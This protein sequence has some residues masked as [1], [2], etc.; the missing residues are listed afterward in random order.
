MHLPEQAFAS[1][2][3]CA[4]CWH[5]TGIEARC[6][7]PAMLAEL[8]YA[9]ETRSPGYGLSERSEN[10]S[11]RYAPVIW[12]SPALARYQPGRTLKL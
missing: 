11:F 3:S 5:A 12:H 1:N 4:N 10:V 7:S 2:W 8:V 6:H 9:F